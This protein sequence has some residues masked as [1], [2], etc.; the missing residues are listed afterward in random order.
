M[1]FFICLLYIYFQD[2]TC[3]QFLAYVVAEGDGS[4]VQSAV[5]TLS[6]LADSPECRPPLANTFGVIEALQSIAELVILQ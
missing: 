3:V 4:L 1:L 5:D 2:K 6:L